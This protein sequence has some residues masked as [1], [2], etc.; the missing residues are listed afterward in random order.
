MLL[1]LQKLLKKIYEKEKS[2]KT[3]DIK[4]QERIAELKR[5][6]VCL[7]ICPVL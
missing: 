4:E 5:Q 1:K 2:A 3:E 6:E 7:R